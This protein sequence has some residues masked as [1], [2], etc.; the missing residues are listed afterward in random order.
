[1]VRS[2][3][4][5]PTRTS[6]L[7]LRNMKLRRQSTWSKL[8][9]TRA[10]QLTRN[11][12]RLSNKVC[13]TLHTLTVTLTITITYMYMWSQ[14]LMPYNRYF[15]PGE[16]FSNFHHLLPLAKILSTNFFS[17]IMVTQW[18]WR[19]LP[20][21]RKLNP[22]KFSCNTRVLALAK[23]FS[24]EIFPLYSI[25]YVLVCVAHLQAPPSFGCTHALASFV[26]RPS[27]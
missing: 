11:G 18:T 17:C 23:F 13:I 26:S 16:I 4:S 9:A 1:M 19:S 5:C 6:N 22:V 10:H 2:G 21:W 20:H 24:R 15:S 8:S 14:T 3:E 25:M 27:Q 12:W 7:I